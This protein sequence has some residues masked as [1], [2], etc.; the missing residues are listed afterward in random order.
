MTI[1]NRP[2]IDEWLTACWLQTPWPVQS[3]HMYNGPV[4]FLETE[5]GMVVLLGEWFDRVICGVNSQEHWQALLERL[6]DLSPLPPMDVASQH[7]DEEPF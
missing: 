3:G 4:V 6:E 5:H 2:D 7:I 1:A